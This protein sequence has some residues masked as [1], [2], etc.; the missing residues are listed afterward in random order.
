MSSEE[1]KKNPHRISFLIENGDKYI[2]Y[3]LSKGNSDGEI[4]QEIEELNLDIRDNTDVYEG[5]CCLSDS[6]LYSLVKQNK[7]E[8]LKF[9]L[10]KYGLYNEDMFQCIDFTDIKHKPSLELIISKGFDPIVL[11]PY[12]FRPNLVNDALYDPDHFNFLFDTFHKSFLLMKQFDKGDLK[13]MTFPKII[14]LIFDCSTKEST[15]WFK[16]L[17]GYCIMISYYINNWNPNKVEPKKMDETR[18]TR[19]WF[20]QPLRSC[21]Y[22]SEFCDQFIKHQIEFPEFRM[23]CESNRDK[24]EDSWISK[25]ESIL[26]QAIEKHRVKDVNQNADQ[27]TDQ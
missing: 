2:K 15:V 17:L 26:N 19:D 1:E 27:K 24:I 10:E 25:V 4:I 3:L 5:E 7:L 9:Y 18:Q 22:L 21:I 13:V 8:I 12:S 11:I 16:V 14:D 20:L 23:L 6:L